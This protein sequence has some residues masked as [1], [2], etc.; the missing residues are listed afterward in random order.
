MQQKLLFPFKLSETK[1]S[2]AKITSFGGVPLMLELYRALGLDRVVEQHLRVKQRG[3]AENVLLE[4]LI[5]LQVAG[6]ACMDDVDVLRADDAKKLAGYAT[7]PS[8]AAVG[9][10]LHRFDV[11]VSEPRSLGSAF[12]P[13]ENT[14]LQA[15]A[16]VNRYLVRQ[17]V[18]KTN[19][20]V[21]T[22]DVDATVVHSSKKLAL[23]TYKGGTG[24][25]P[26]QAVWAE[27]QVI[28]AEQFRD[29]NVNAHADALAFLQRIEKHIPKTQQNHKRKLRL[30]SDGAWYQHSIMEYC[31]KQGYEFSISADVS[32]S[33]KRFVQALA[34]TE[35]HMLDEITKEGKA[36]TTKEYA[37]LRF[38]SASLSQAEMRE[39]VEQYRYLIIRT[40]RS[41]VDV[42]EGAYH[43]NA[44]VTNMDWQPERQIA[45]HY[46]RCG[47]IEQVIDILKNDLGGGTLPCGTFGANAAWWRITC[48]THNLVQT[49]KIIALPA[50][51]FYTRMKKLRFKLFC[52]A[53]RIIS[54]ARQMFL[55]LTRG[56]P[57]LPIYREARA[58]LAAF[59]Q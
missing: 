28:L 30:R 21:M 2:S 18:E 16:E 35:W 54:H 48:L 49:L 45:W 22:I 40:P 5:V 58:R 14:L 55:Q 23:E 8:S 57:I 15:L 39:R 51:W 20:P 50:E 13:A 31:V 9:R 34:E 24:Y 56:H 33:L 52:V 46:E 17:L 42:L 44:I 37:E 43:Y 26:M 53:G 10:F 41:Q 47:S 36:T 3:W 4:E 1:K 7:L 12:I 29:G 59:A 38:T 19:P 27:T 32:S 11:G 25:Q 6:G